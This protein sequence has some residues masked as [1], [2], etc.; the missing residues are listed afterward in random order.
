MKRSSN[1]SSSTWFSKLK[2]ALITGASAGFGAEFARQL[3]SRCQK[4]IRVARRLDRLEALQQELLQQ[5]PGLIVHPLQLDLEAPLEV[6]RLIQW[7]QEGKHEVTWLI[8]NAGLG[9]VGE[10]ATAE[11]PRVRPMLTVN[12]MALTRLTHALLPAMIRVGEGRVLNIGS[13]A[14]YLPLP[15]FAVYAASKAYVNNFSEALYWELHGT[16]VTVTAVCPGPVQTE[17]LEVA[18]RTGGRKA[19]HA[20]KFVEISAAEVVSQSLRGAEAGKPRVV[21]GFWI[22]A[23]SLFFSKLPLCWM[24]VLYRFKVVSAP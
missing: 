5:H 7:V 20:P 6:E 8:N 12:M 10:L 9:D 11:W 24:R 13:I 16:G 23:C 1:Q 17:F 18:A 19:F 2:T 3:A 14:G 21:P 4:L 22:H 15:G